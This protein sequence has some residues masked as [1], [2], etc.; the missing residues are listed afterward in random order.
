[1][2]PGAPTLRSRVADALLYAAAAMLVAIVCINFVNV[3]GRYLFAHALEWGEETM[4]FLMI[5][6]VFLATAKVTLDREHIRMDLLLHR[7]GARARG[8][9]ELVV[10]AVVI[11]TLMTVTCAGFPVIV[12]LI[13][14]GQK[15]EG[16]GIPVA[17]PQLAVPI[18]LGTA[19]L[20]LLI[21]IFADR[22]RNGD[23]AAEES[24]AP[25][26]VRT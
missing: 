13:Q 22:T 8:W 16:S 9:A 26:E 24:T 18:G 4:Q 10:D 15:S 7:L 11:G 5:G 3:T 1:M 14:F 2:R 6:G 12:K 21:G 20:L 17:I 25:V 23:V 19:A